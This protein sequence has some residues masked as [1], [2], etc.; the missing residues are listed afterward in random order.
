MNQAKPISIEAFN[1][2]NSGY[3]LTSTLPTEDDPNLDTPPTNL[4]LTSGN[5]S[6][7]SNSNNI[8]LRNLIM[9]SNYGT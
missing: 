5:N 9:R 4:R 6:M 1:N 8:V 3:S 2:P 7:D